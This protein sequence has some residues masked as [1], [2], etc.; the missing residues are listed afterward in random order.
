MRP[1]R[2]ESATGLYWSLHG[3]VACASHAPTSDDPRWSRE[4]WA[5]IAVVD[6]RV[7]DSRYE[8]QCRHCAPDGRVER[9][10]C[11][12]DI[13]ERIQGHKDNAAKHQRRAE[14]H[15]Q[16]ADRF[17]ENAKR[18]QAEAPPACD[19]RRKKPRS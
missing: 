9:D 10:A 12:N 16:A 3:E 2:P 7:P 14:Q 4:G 17:M 6:R 1:R 18:R 5:P 19:E 11:L 13:V 15:Q 8:Y